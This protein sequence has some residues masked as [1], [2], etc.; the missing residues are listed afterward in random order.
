MRTVT[1]GRPAVQHVSF[2]AQVKN[3]LNKKK[4]KCSFACLVCLYVCGLI[5]QTSVPAAAA[6]QPHHWGALFKQMDHL[7]SI[8]RLVKFLNDNKTSRFSADQNRYT[9]NVKIL[10][11]YLFHYF[12]SNSPSLIYFSIPQTL[13]FLPPIRTGQRHLASGWVVLGPA[14]SSQWWRAVVPTWLAC[15]PG[16]RWWT[17]RA[18]MLPISA[19]LLSS[20]WLRP[21]KQYL[22][23]SEWCRGSN[24]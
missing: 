24:K 16:T 4:K 14:I 1:R 10:V 21:S 7:T 11:N 15:S 9:V 12:K 8:L 6:V 13:V 2:I 22:P 20:H 17:L 3:I 19:L 23:A 18:R 5:K